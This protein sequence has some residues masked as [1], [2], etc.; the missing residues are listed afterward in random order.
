MTQTMAYKPPTDYYKR[1]NELI[2]AY[3]DR[4]YVQE[5]NRWEAKINKVSDYPDLV[6][7]SRQAKFQLKL[8]NE[9]PF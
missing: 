2:L 6:N 5:A 3:I 8:L 4:G 1:I 7:L 9:R